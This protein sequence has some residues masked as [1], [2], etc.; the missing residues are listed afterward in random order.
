VS[1]ASIPVQAVS[2]R[3]AG[4][5]DWLRFARV[6]QWSKNV[7]L[8]LPMLTAHAYGDAASVTAITAGILALSLAASATYVV[9]DILDVERDRLHPTKRARL[10]AARR[11]TP[12]MAAALAAALVCGGLAVATALGQAFVACLCAYCLASLA[13]SLRLKLVPLLDVVVLGLLYTGR[14]AM[15]A[16]LAG[17]AQSPWLLSFAALFFTSLAF[18]KRHAEVYA[19][20][21]GQYALHGRG[22]R[23]EDWP[24]TLACGIGAFSGCIVLLVVYLHEQTALPGPYARPWCLWAVPVLTAVWSLRIWLLAHRGELHGDPVSFAL[25]DTAS[26]GCGAA[27][28]LAFVA[29]TA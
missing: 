6:H 22:Y 8:L 4:F 20:A 23:T 17:V 25:R 15:G 13:Y 16:L 26:L 2:D 7:L 10:L 5:V 18:A 1:S 29:A 19:A 24:L 12:G 21:R 11:I 3:Q 14:I 28:L 27:T 9:N